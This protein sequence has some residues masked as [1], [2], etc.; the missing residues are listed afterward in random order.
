MKKR[1]LTL[2][3]LVAMALPLL[4][5]PIQA[6]SED[7]EQSVLATG[8]P[9]MAIDI[10]DGSSITDRETY[11]AATMEITLTKEYANYTNAYTGSGGGA[12][13]I[14][15]RGNSSWWQFS[16]QKRAFN[17]KLDKKTE[18]FGM[19]SSKKWC[20]IANFM[21]RSNLR[22]KL[23]YELSARLGMTYCESVFVNLYLNGKYMGVYMLCERADVD[24]EIYEWEDVAEDIA[25]AVKKADSLSKEQKN[26]LED[27]LKEDLE[28]MTSDSFTF[29]GRDYKVS[30]YIDI[31][32]YSLQGG[33]LIEY[34]HYFDQISKFSTS[35]GV[36]LNLQSPEYLATNE[37]VM[38]Y[39]QE[40]FADFEEAVNSESFYNSKGHHYSEYVNMDSLVDFFIV[41]AFFLN[42]EF[43]YKSNYLYIDETGIITFGPVWD[44]DWSSGNHFLGSSGAYDQWYGGDWRTVHNVWY[45]QIY[46]DP[47]FVALVQERWFEIT[48]ILKETIAS[49]DTYYAYLNAASTY[50]TQHYLGL[51]GENDFRNQYHGYNYQQ[52]CNMLKTFLQ[53]RYN[54]MTQQLSAEK[55]NI[56]GHG[57]SIDTRMELTLSGDG[58]T[59]ISAKRNGYYIDYTLNADY[60]DEITLDFSLVSTAG[61]TNHF[62]IYINEKYYTTVQSQDFTVT[63]PCSMFEDG[64]NAVSAVRVREGE[65]YGTRT[66]VTVVADIS[67]RKIEN[68]TLKI[69]PATMLVNIEKTTLINKSSAWTTYVTDHSGFSSTN[70]SNWKDLNYN[71]RRWKVC[72]A[73][74]GDRLVPANA[75]VTG[76]KGDNHVLFARQKFNVDLSKLDAEDLYLDVYYD[77]TVYIY[78]N[79]NLVYSDDNAVTGANDWTDSYKLIKLSGAAKYLVNGTNI[80]AVSLQDKTGG[81]ELDMSV[82]AVNLRESKQYVSPVTSESLDETLISSEQDGMRTFLT[83]SRNEKGDGLGVWLL[84]ENEYF[85]KYANATVTVKLVATNGNTKTVSSRISKLESFDCIVS[86]GKAFVCDEESEF[87]CLTVE[88]MSKGQWKEIVI[89]VTGSGKTLKSST[90]SYETLKSYY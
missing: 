60:R 86:D 15:G 71:E 35:S 75:D 46:G 21:D 70:S 84:A 42:V 1:I 73:P 72:N 26:A 63:V 31:S 69:T 36:P 13:E 17:I 12:L 55:P 43:G 47:Y 57:P 52:E 45:H 10:D 48:D 58:V 37:T 9:V 30:D 34:D 88:G 25:S 49:V 11:K 81:R 40:L 89:E 87:L 56:E 16:T 54:W 74:L 61:V 83:L 4:S 14:K 51:S 28:W 33:Y 90:V 18:L 59:D 50:E 39:M 2:V 8:L 68:A 7:I 20:L 38:N 24:E 67:S 79:G 23:A 77:N 65:Y 85:D 64:I 22:N 5:S 82:Y 44:F 32:E 78:I 27:V 76:W 19:D 41:N 29:E 53:N 6:L 80:I 62:E 3:L 66:Y